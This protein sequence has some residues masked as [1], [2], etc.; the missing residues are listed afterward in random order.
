MTEFRA[1]R[2]VLPEPE[3]PRVVATALGIDDQIAAFDAVPP[4]C[5]PSEAPNVVIVVMDDL[6]YGTSSAFGGP[7]SMPAADQLASGGLRFSRF[8]VTALCSPTRQS[9]MTGRN[10]HSV[11]MGGGPQ[12]AGAARKNRRA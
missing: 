11:G 2:H 5:P 8:H 7:C 6:G 9:L 3:R 10:H 12:A 4:T 1:Q